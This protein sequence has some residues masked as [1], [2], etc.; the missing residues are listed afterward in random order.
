MFFEIEK[1]IPEREKKNNFIMNSSTNNPERY[2]CKYKIIILDLS[3]RTSLL[4][5]FKLM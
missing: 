3:K 2:I 5:F 4:F 1:N